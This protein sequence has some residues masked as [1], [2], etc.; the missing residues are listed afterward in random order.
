ML[1]HID[2]PLISAELTC[3]RDPDCPSHEFRQRVRRIA[4]LMVPAVT[5]DLERAVV[6]CQTPL[7][8]TSGESIARPII[9]VPKARPKTIEPKRKFIKDKP[10]K[11]GV[12][13]KRSGKS[14]SF[15]RDK[16]KPRNK[17]A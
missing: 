8:I 11:G 13:P 12:R 3:L 10:F 9:L 6:P 16:N 17:A 4:S 5:A 1:H 14:F 2:H 15:H 7:E